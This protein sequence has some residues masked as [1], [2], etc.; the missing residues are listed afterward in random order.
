MASL[1]YSSVTEVFTIRVDNSG[2]YGLPYEIIGSKGSYAS[3]TTSEG[4]LVT[5]VHYD[6][7]AWYPDYDNETLE[8]Y[9]GYDLAY[10]GSWCW[11]G[12]KLK[13]GECVETNDAFSLYD[14]EIILN[15]YNKSTGYADITVICYFWNPNDKLQLYLRIQYFYYNY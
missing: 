11:D 2:G 10:K 14:Y 3:G 1:Q 4:G 7:Y 13:S 5:Q 8:L 15:S 12:S 6:G 9:I